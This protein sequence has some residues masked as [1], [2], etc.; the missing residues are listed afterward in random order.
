[1]INI[2]I[3]ILK[4][5][6]LLAFSY[7]F[8]FFFVFLFIIFQILIFHYFISFL[9]SDINTDQRSF[10]NMFWFIVFGIACLDISYTIISHSSIQVEEFKRSGILE[11][12]IS[13]INNNF[14]YFISSTIY[15]IIISI[16]KLLLYFL[17][18]WYFEPSLSFIGS[19]YQ[20]LLSFFLFLLSCSA[21]SI[22]AVSISLIFHRGTI[23]IFAHNS[24]AIILGGVMFPSSMISSNFLSELIMVF[25]PI[26]SFLEIVRYN[27]GIADTLISTS[28]IYLALQTALL[29]A[30]S[31]IMLKISLKY[32]KMTGSINHF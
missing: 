10:Q 14:F 6:F 18:G 19:I 11:E 27:F 15:P 2:F 8:R 13:T 9:G 29:I 28:V 7:K 32:S 30:I 20:V 23:I 5:D 17:A 1:M 3:S 12:N 16:L 25:L 26:R 22:I 21:I 31:L 4:R 24:L